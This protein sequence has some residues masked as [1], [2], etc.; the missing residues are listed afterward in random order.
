MTGDN[1]Y[2]H[3]TWFTNPNQERASVIDLGDGK[4]SIESSME[5]EGETPEAVMVNPPNLTSS[6]QNWNLD[7]LNT[8]PFWAHR[9]R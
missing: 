5:L 4:L 8:M 9:V 1:E 3:A 2:A 6:R 7:S